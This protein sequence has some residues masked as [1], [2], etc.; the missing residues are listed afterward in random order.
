MVTAQVG[1]KE[2][3]RKKVTHRLLFT[4]MFI[5]IYTYNQTAV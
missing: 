3:E 1:E 2:S 5:C 4:V